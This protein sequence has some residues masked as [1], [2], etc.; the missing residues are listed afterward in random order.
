MVLMAQAPPSARTAEPAFRG[1][2]G[3]SSVNKR[4]AVRRVPPVSSA[5]VTNAVAP[6]GCSRKYATAYV[7]QIHD[8]V[9]DLVP[10]LEDRAG[11]GQPGRWQARLGRFE[12]V[13]VWALDRVS[14][15]GVEATLAILRRFAGH[16]AAVWSLKEPRTETADPRMAGLLA[17]LYAGMAAEG[18]RRCRSGPRPGRSAVSRRACRPAAGRDIRSRDAAMDTWRRGRERAVAG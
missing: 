6:G 10:G 1:A 16:G 15:G 17:S 3:A 2:V 5:A 4:S 9:R 13:L 7:Y 18:S 14:P 12:I 8:Q 11:D